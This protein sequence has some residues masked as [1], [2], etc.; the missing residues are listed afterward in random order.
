MLPA[1][2]QRTRSWVRSQA[3]GL[4]TSELPRFVARAVSALL[5]LSALSLVIFHLWLFWHRWEAGG[6]SDPLVAAR[7]IGS[8]LLVAGLALARRRRLLPEGRQ[9]LV[10]WM[11]IALV[12]VGANHPE[13]NSSPLASPGLL[14]VAPGAAGAAL[15]AA[16]ALVR[17]ARRRRVL[18]SALRVA[19]PRTPREG[20]PRAPFL[21]NPRPLRAPPIC[22]PV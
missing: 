13:I 19:T 1:V 16:A 7:W 4:G 8:A 22:V 2:S 15:L 10:V 3:A 21:T 20:R 12:H 5:V 6:F 9:A 11:L 18:V 17:A 14:F